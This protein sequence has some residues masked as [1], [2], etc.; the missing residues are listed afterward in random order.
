MFCLAKKKKKKMLHLNNLK[1]PQICDFDIT[2]KYLQLQKSSTKS[3]FL[4]L[5]HNAQ[6]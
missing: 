6:Q 5:T 1:T 2:R 4:F 3:L